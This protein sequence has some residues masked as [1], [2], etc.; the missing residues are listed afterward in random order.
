MKTWNQHLLPLLLVA[1]LMT[2]CV[3]TLDARTKTT[4]KNLRSTQ[5]P[6]AV[7][8]NSDGVLPDS[9][10]GIDPNAV[11]L[12]GYSK[13]ASD[14]K[15]SFFV[16]NNTKHRMSAVRLLLRY[17]AMNGEMLTQ[18]TVTVPVSLKPGETKLVEIKSFDVQRMFY[19][20]AGPQ[21]RKQATPFKVAFRLT[22]YDIPV[23]N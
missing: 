13:R 5:V 17:T 21:P 12:K 18:R 14:S 23:G 3:N 8:E 6:V 7:M 20:Y 1:A 15:E 19:Y 16:T 2:L 4:R 22:G 9:L 10:Q 11:T